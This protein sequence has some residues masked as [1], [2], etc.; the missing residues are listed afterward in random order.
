MLVYPISAVAVP[1]GH[2]MDAGEACGLSEGGQGERLPGVP[3]R[4]PAPYPWLLALHA[5]DEKQE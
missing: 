2:E 4:A 5:A 3:P 1:R